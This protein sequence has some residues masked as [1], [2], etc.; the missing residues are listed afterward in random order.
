VSTPVLSLEQVSKTYPLPGGRSFTALAGAS[1]E[2]GPRRTVSITGRSGS[3]KSTLL[4]LAAG[5]DAPTAGRV[6]LL[7]RDLGALGDRERTLARREQVGLVFQFF[8]LLPHLSV[9]D[10]VLLPALIEGRSREDDARAEALLAR[11]GLADAADR[12]VRQYSKGM[13][14]RLLFAQALLGA[15][16]ILFLDEPTHGLDPAGVCEFYAMLAELRAD[17]VTV[18][19]TSHVL[20]EVEQRVDRLALMNNGRLQA[21]GT[22]QALREALDLPLA[23]DVRIRD[24]GERA[25]RAA[26]TPLA[27]EPEVRDGCARFRCARGTK[28][29][30]LAAL[31]GL[32]SRLV[33]VNLKEPTLE[34]VFLGYRKAA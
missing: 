20:S 19:L 27:I 26:L 22:V 12:P 7:G 31:S 18:V 11:V 15:P 23:F 5:I 24:G 34:D 30:V 21:V 4:H 16:R 10:N 33:D 3:G 25:L 29:A 13:A 17:G 28:L 9:R 32:G 6:L 8:H 14:Q 2:V 1:L